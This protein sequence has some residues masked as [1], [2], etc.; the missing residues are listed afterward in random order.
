MSGL[1]LGVV[2]LGVKRRKRVRLNESEGEIGEGFAARNKEKPPRLWHGWAA[3][4]GVMYELEED[5]EMRERE[6][7]EGWKLEHSKMRR[8]TKKKNK[9]TKEWVWEWEGLERRREKKYILNAK[10]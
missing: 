4:N 9:K 7:W 6:S 8:K 5:Y 10:L 3:I 1:G 2:K